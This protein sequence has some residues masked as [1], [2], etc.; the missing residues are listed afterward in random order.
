MDLHKRLLGPGCHV[1]GCH[2]TYSVVVHKNSEPYSGTVMNVCAKHWRKYDDAMTVNGYKV[3]ETRSTYDD[4][5][6]RP[7]QRRPRQQ[8]GPFSK[9]RE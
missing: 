8:K 9:N 5:P 3:V 4:P 1:R 7:R 2:A 6:P